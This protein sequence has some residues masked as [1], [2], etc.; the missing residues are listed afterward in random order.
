MHWQHLNLYF[1]FLYV[2]KMKVKH[3]TILRLQIYSDGTRNPPI[4]LLTRK[5]ISLV[6]PLPT[7]R[8]GSM[9]CRR[10]WVFLS[11]FFFVILYFSVHRLLS[12]MFVLQCHLPLL[13]GSRRQVRIGQGPSDHVVRIFVAQ[14]LH[15]QNRMVSFASN[16]I[17]RKLISIWKYKLRSIIQK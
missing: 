6:S 8:R 10:L 14:V 12:R 13:F 16:L 9:V 15:Y 5:G 3:S 7:H 11:S 2:V 1:A 17:M 4:F